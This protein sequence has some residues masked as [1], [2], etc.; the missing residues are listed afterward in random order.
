M[1]RWRSATHRERARSVS[2]VREPNPKSPVRLHEH[3]LRMRQHMHSSSSKTDVCEDTVSTGSLTLEDEVAVGNTT[4]SSSMGAHTRAVGHHSF[5]GS[6]STGCSFAPEASVSAL[7]DLEED[8]MT[9]LEVSNASLGAG[10]VPERNSRM[11]VSLPANQLSRLYDYSWFVHSFI[12]ML[13]AQVAESVRQASRS[14][15]ARNLDY[16]Q[17]CTKSWT[18]QIAEV[19]VG[20]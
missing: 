20:Q 3:L 14:T 10:S 1:R 18:E 6:L 9:D 5:S 7:L 2:P 19:F 15:F 16:I 12:E 17:F 13:Q 8:E 11:P 4:N